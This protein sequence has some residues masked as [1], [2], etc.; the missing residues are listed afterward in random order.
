LSPNGIVEG[1]APFQ[2]VRGDPRPLLLY[3]S[4][5]ASR[6]SLFFNP[7]LEKAEIVLLNPWAKTRESLSKDDLAFKMVVDRRLLIV[8]EEEG[9]PSV[10]LSGIISTGT[11][12]RLGGEDEAD[13]KATELL[14]FDDMPVVVSWRSP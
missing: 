1:I 6:S 9:D 13:G 4:I 10:V 12:A 5:S 7:G 8:R 2:R 11:T 14:I 3:L